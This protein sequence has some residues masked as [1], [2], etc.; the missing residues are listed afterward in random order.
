MKRSQSCKSLPQTPRQDG[1]TCGLTQKKRRSISLNDVPEALAAMRT[2]YQSRNERSSCGINPEVFSRGIPS[3]K[4]Q[5]NLDTLI[6]KSS[7]N[8]FNNQVFQN[9]TQQGNSEES[10]VT[11]PQEMRQAIKDEM[12]KPR[13]RLHLGSLFNSD[14]KSEKNSPKKRKNGSLSPTSSPNSTGS[15]N[16][17]KR[18]ASRSTS[19]HRSPKSIISSK[20]SPKNDSDDDIHKKKKRNSHPLPDDKIIRKNRADSITDDKSPKTHNILSMPTDSHNRVKKTLVLSDPD[21]KKNQDSDDKKDANRK[22][23]ARDKKPLIMTEPTKEPHREKKNL[24]ISDPSSNKNKTPVDEVLAFDFYQKYQHHPK[25]DIDVQIKFNDDFYSIPWGLSF[26]VN[27]D[28]NKIVFDKDDRRKFEMFKIVKVKDDVVRCEGVTEKDTR[29]LVMELKY[30]GKYVCYKGSNFI[31]IKVI[32][33]TCNNGTILTIY[34]QKWRPF[35][36][37]VYFNYYNKTMKINEVAPFFWQI[38]EC[39]EAKSIKLN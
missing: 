7:S 35:S 10:N 37:P 13:F 25:E 5:I 14:Q 21:E 2:E 17:E 27:E 12:E 11:S 23:V 28:E 19:P 4:D 31:K 33:D 30:V 22:D 15:P 20:G 6:Y 34:S 39:I 36:Y 26:T 3:P 1:N 16:K 8:D 24:F 9:K 29:R 18:S 32:E 38:M